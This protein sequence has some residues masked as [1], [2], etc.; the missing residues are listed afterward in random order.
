MSDTNQQTTQAR[1]YGPPRPHKSWLGALEAMTME[2]DASP[3]TYSL[4]IPQ[5]KELW[6]EI[7]KLLAAQRQV[8]GA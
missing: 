2:E 6:R 3:R 7:G 5:A 1:S 4:T 8:L